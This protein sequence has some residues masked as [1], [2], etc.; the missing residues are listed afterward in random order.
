MKTLQELRWMQLHAIY[1]NFGL[2]NKD[3][4]S[5]AFKPGIYVTLADE[6]P[7]TMSFDNL[8]NIYLLSQVTF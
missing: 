4:T 2:E 8:K 1:V 3:D 7:I 5:L 6:P